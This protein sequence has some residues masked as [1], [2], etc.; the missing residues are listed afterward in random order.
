MFNKNIKLK[1]I[2][3]IG[4][5]VA[6]SITGSCIQNQCMASDNPA[7]SYYQQKSQLA[8]DLELYVAQTRRKVKNNWYPPTASFENSATIVLTINKEGKLENCYLSNP[9]PDEGFNESLINAARK[10]VYSPLPEEYRGKSISIDLDFS[11]QR[12]TISK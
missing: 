2:V 3:L 11:M 1:N 7:N 5:L 4:M 8:Q 9:S 12:R 10:T 6:F